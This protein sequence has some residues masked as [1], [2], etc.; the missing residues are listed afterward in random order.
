MP[1]KCPVCKTECNENAT[2]CS[3]CGF[4]DPQGIDYWGITPEAAQYKLEAII[5]PARMK[6]EFEEE[7]NRA[8]REAK[9]EVSAMQ[10]KLNVEAI[11]EDEY[12]KT[13]QIIRSGQMWQNT[14]S[15]QRNENS[16]VP[17][18]RG[19]FRNCYI[20]SG[21]DYIVFVIKSM[22]RGCFFT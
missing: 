22:S 2:T 6:R 9:A 17:N 11:K 4:T 5:K 16:I 1:E 21:M 14:G 13:P 20:K 10:L 3:V 18:Q 19:F 15:S 12:A 7:L 8:K